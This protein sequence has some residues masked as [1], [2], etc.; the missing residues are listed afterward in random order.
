MLATTLHVPS[1]PRLNSRTC[2]M[3]GCPSCGTTGSTGRT[4]SP[5][6]R[7]AST[8]LTTSAPTLPACPTAPP[9]ERYERA[10]QKRFTCLGF[11]RPDGCLSLLMQCLPIRRQSTVHAAAAFPLTCSSQ[12]K[13]AAWLQS[14]EDMDRC[15]R[16]RGPGLSRDLRS[17]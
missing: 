8:I 5:R 7:K 12:V 15:S 4:R 6:T 10:A 3:S 2:L 13:V 14:S 16:G 17:C 11:N 1:S 9:S